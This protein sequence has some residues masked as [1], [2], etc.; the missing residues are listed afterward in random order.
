M[1]AQ[2][3]R[4]ILEAAREL[5]VVQGY[6]G[7]GTNAIIERAGVSRGSFFYHFPDKSA[8]IE[9]TIRLYA[10]DSLFALLEDAFDYD[11]HPKDALNAHIDALEAWHLRERFSGGCLLGNMALELS[12][13]DP[14]ARMRISICFDRWEEIIAQR[15]EGH[16]LSM[17]TP[18]F[19]TL[20]IASIEGVTLLSRVHKCAD[21]ASREFSACRALVSLAFG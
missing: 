8:L 6:H 21:R 10:E 13:T 1:A 14:R 2:T 18:D 20:Y 12:D 3:K 11:A 9:E 7:T 5:I 4:K 17:N 16:T 15:L 19:V